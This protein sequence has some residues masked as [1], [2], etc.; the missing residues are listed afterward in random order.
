[1]DLGYAYANK[2]GGR[3]ERRVRL[4]VGAATREIAVF[5]DRTW[6]DW[7]TISKPALFSRLP[8]TYDRAFGGRCDLYLDPDSPLEVGPI[9][10]QLGTAQ[11]L[12]Q[13]RSTGI[14]PWN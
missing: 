14:P 9:S 4:K 5:G 7:K 2:K 3:T 8:L 6:L 10:D 1:M 13:H 12:G 11:C